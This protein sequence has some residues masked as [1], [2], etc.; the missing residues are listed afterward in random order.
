MDSSLLGVNDVEASPLVLV[1]LGPPGAG[2]GTHAAPLSE[3][4]GLPHVSTGDLFRKHIQQQTP[5]G[6]T[7]KNYMNQGNLVPDEL[8]LDMLFER[9]KAKDCI[10]GCILDGFPRTLAQA[11]SLDARLKNKSRLLA[12][13]FNVADAI[14]IERITGRLVCRDCKRPYHTTFDPPQEPGF[15]DPC[16]GVLFTRDDDKEMIVRKRLAVY[17]AE[18]LPLIEYYLA[19]GVLKEIDAQNSKPQVFQDVL[20]AIP[21]LVHNNVKYLSPLD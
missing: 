18:T 16:G 11:R 10:Q 2:K 12:L 1:L 9:L 13:N 20:E 4:L 6:F 5:L 19:K 14:L 21:L 8:V 17:R 7:A 3:A 15:C